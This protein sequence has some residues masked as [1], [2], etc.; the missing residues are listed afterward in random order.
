MPFFIPVQYYDERYQVNDNLS[1]L[2]DNHVVQ[3]GVRV[4]RRGL[5]AD[6]PRLRQRALHLQLDRRLP[7]LRPQSRLRR[8]LERRPARPQN[9]T[10]PAGTPRHRPGAALSAARRRRRPHGGRGG[11]A[12]DPPERARGLP[13]G[14]LAAAREPDDPVR[15]ALG[16]AR[17]SPSRARRRTRSSSRRSSA[18][19]CST[20]AGPQTFPSDGEIPS[21]WDMWQP[22]LGI[23]WDPKG[24]GR[25]AVRLTGGIFY[26]RVPGLT[27]ASS[28][29][30]N[31]SIGQSLFRSSALRR[32]LGPVPAYP[33]LIP[34]VAGRRAVR[35]RRLRLRQG[36]P[37]P[38]HDLGEPLVR[39][40]DH[41]A[42]S[43]CWSS[44]T[45]PRA[46]TSPA[47]STATIRSS[48][49]PGAPACRRAAP[50][51]STR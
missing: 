27:L 6:L 33:G 38:A 9:G 39:A 31:G 10:C 20:A 41:V 21:D 2:R 43:A 8:V 23:T 19:R 28:R 35:P 17:S 50:T 13:A 47:S 34:P 45:T 11:A 25:S 40:G 24:D 5:G 4:Q 16:G 29:S 32:I 30:T 22:R 12:E 42:A 1:I 51:A 46:T 7:Q 36:F 3:G 26:A 37:E 44:T 49:R 48:A 14:Q 15:P 18:A